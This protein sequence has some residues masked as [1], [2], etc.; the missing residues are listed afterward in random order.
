MWRPPGQKVPELPPSGPD[1]PPEDVQARSLFRRGLP[2]HISSRLFISIYGGDGG[3]LNPGCDNIRLFGPF[4]DVRHRSS[5]DR[6]DLS[7]AGARA[8][9]ISKCAEQDRRPGSPG[10]I[11]Q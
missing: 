7:S 9:G 2:F 10:Y 5:V 1:D 4:G 8:N 11:N 6:A 3:H